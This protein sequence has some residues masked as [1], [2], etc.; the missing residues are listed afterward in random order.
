MMSS[1]PKFRALIAGFY[2]APNVGDE[3]LLDL[4]LHRIRELGGESV[5][6]SIDAALTRR[7]HGVDTVDF[8]NL[9]ALGRALMDCDVLVMGGGGI[10][11][12][13]HAFNL[14]AVYQP[15]TNDIASYARPMLLARQLGVPTIVWAHGVGPLRGEG[16]RALV[17]VL[18]QQATAVSVRDESS[19]TLLQQIGVDRD[20]VVAADPG[21]LFRRYHP[22]PVYAEAGEATATPQKVLAVVVREWDKGQWETSLVAALRSAVPAQWRIQWV[23]FQ[24]NTEGSG[25]ISDLPVIERLREQIGERAGDDLA[26]P[27]TPEQAWE[28]LAQADAVLSMR[29]HASILALLAGKPTA[30]L[31]YDDKLAHAN[32][33]V[34][35]PAAQRLS[36]DAD[37]A[38]FSAAIEALLDEDPWLPDPEVLAAL[39]QSADAHFSLLDA[40]VDLPPREI[41]FNADHTDWI[42]LWLQQTLTELE[43]VKQ[44]SGR[45][46]DL[47]SYRDIQLAEGAK[48]TEQLS[49]QLEDTKVIADERQTQ[50]KE[51]QSDLDRSRQKMADAQN[52]RRRLCDAVVAVR[53]SLSRLIAAPFKVATVWRRYG[54]KAALKQIFHWFRT[55][56]EPRAMLSEQLGT[57]PAIV[58]PVREERLLVLAGTLQDADGWPSRAMQLAKAGDRAGFFVRVTAMKTDRAPHGSEQ[59]ARLYVDEQAWLQELRA[60]STRVLLADASARALALAGSA[61]DRGAEVIVD[62]GALGLDALTPEL[63]KVASRVIGDRPD[64]TADGVPAQWIGDAGD[65]EIFDSYRTYP[66]PDAYAADR[67]NVLFMCLG[68][69]GGDWLDAA[70]RADENLILHVVGSGI[71]GRDPERLRALEWSW[72]PEAMAPLIASAQA[73]VIVGGA[74]RADR[75]AHLSMAALLLEKPVFV[76]HLPAFD[77]SA[78]L[79]LVDAAQLTERL[80]NTV[81]VEDYAFVSRHAWL[82]H[83]ERLMQPAYPPSVSV[84]VLI[85]NNRRIIERCVSTLLEHAGQWL[86]EIVVVDNKS[87]DGGAEL[88]ESLYADNPKVKLVRNT[89]NGCASGRNLG[90]KHSTGEYIAFFDSDQWVTSPSCF[91]EATAIMAADKGIGTIGWNAGWFD[92]LRD[93]LG[94]PIS[95]YLPNRGMNAEAKIKG[96]RDDIG[97]LGTSCMFIRRELFDRL[98]GF[99]TFYDPTCFEDTDI[100]FQVKKAGYSVTFRDLAG[101]RHQPHQTTGASE[102]SERYKRLFNRNAA[103]FREKWKTY[104][105]FFVALKSWH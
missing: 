104:P 56:G 103:Y 95:D 76:D 40:C 63:R 12:D 94:G 89:E 7:M 28:V 13:H 10:F 25:A 5:V 100:C 52:M 67:P 69:Y 16:A 47:L 34:G 80:G 99:D 74:D 14:E 32:A 24:A 70:L 33:M 46:H 71:D 39:E 86:Q 72:Q 1:K 8:F 15:F 6:A 4:L 22:L 26:T 85:Y 30:S 93:D 75:L 36:V 3:A 83:V 101:V 43:R 2:G 98:E 44:D 59:L 60:E 9:G 82:G 58:K 73:V 38:R 97:F 57:L 19:K 18:F 17:R 96:Y 11:Q 42:L 23:A 49:K 87:S 105:E 31:E 64:V 90:V 54:W 77:A 68:G 35:M 53:R 62:L 66:L 41:G 55:L 37:A 50:I 84:V 48:E 81:G 45:A 88:V 65:N 27:Q 91:A 79:H 21:W 29:L 20:I 61:R 92:P 102:G 51:L 78:N